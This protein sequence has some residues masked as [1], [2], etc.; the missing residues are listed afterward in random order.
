MHGNAHDA[1]NISQCCE[2]Q[3]DVLTLLKHCLQRKQTDIALGGENIILHVAATLRPFF[4]PEQ[5]F[6]M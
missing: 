3:I 1:I 5:H 2:K 4:A 6:W